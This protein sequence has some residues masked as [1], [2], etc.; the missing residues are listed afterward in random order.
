VF[1]FLHSRRQVFRHCGFIRNFSL[2][3]VI[4][5]TQS[6]TFSVR[7]TVKDVNGSPKRKSKRHLR[8]LPTKK[9]LC[10]FVLSKNCFKFSY[11]C[12]SQAFAKLRKEKLDWKNSQKGA[13]ASGAPPM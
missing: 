8:P 5:L 9:R 2:F 11:D 7:S 13:N 3:I 6:E 4:L 10:V 1:H 12:H